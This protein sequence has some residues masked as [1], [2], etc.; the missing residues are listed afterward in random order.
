MARA[1]LHCHSIY[2]EHP[3]EWFLQ[4][5]GAAESYTD[6]KFIYQ[7]LCRRGMDFIVITDHNRIEGALL[8]KE[9][10]PERVIVGMEATTYFPEDGCK[11]HILIYGL[12]EYQYDIIQTIRTNIYELRDYLKQENLAHAVAH[13][14]FSINRKLTIEHLE[15]LILL[16]DVFE[17][18]NGG[19]SRL[20]ND[21]LKRII[22]NMKKEYIDG[23]ERRY[24][25]K[26]FSETPWIKGM[27][28]GSDDHA[29]IFLGLTYT[30]IEADNIEDFL[31][32]IRNKSSKARGRHNDFQ[33][34]AFTVYKIA[35]DFAKTKGKNFSGSFVGKISDYIYNEQSLN[36][37]NKLRLKNMSKASLNSDY[38][39]KR[40]FIELIHTL[41][42]EKDRDT[43]ID[44][45]FKIAYRKIS[46]IADNFF[47]VLLQSFEENLSQGNLIKIIRNISSSLPGVFLTLPFFPPSITCSITGKCSSKCRKGLAATGKIHS[48]KS[49]GLPIP[50]KISTVFP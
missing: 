21:S 41:Q 20:H 44:R 45:R 15:K 16:F 31:E 28:G 38:Q 26:P 1:D 14:T 3:S 32:G 13:A 17:I 40:N 10:Y 47:K 30:E 22:R 39:M 27:V 24:K 49:C 35:L 33:G 9:K 7:E 50:L 12:N 29:G 2:S 4:R 48:T 37:I 43:D 42:R 19:R 23:L 11:I 18:R 5:L 25:I 6:P 46:D 8:L 36:F 34:L